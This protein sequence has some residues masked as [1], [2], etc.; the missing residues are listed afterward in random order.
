MLNQRKKI[1]KALKYK[2]GTR[3]KINEIKSEFFEKINEIS[4][5]LA[6]CIRY[7]RAENIIIGVLSEIEGIVT[8]TTD[9]KG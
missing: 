7:N 5:A 3:K 1:E 8:Y 4:K 9:V 6:C 2:T